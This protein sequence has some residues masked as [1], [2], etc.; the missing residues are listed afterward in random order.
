M[1]I[2]IYIYMHFLHSYDRRLVSGAGL[3][4][5]LAASLSSVPSAVHAR[6]TPVTACDCRR[7]RAR[8]LGSSGFGEPARAARGCLRPHRRL[9]VRTST[10]KPAQLGHRLVALAHEVVALLDH[11]PRVLPVHCPLVSVL[12]IQLRG[13]ALLPPAAGAVG[14]RSG[15]SVHNFFL[16]IGFAF[17]SKFR[18]ASASRPWRSYRKSE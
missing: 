11:L 3:T 9:S 6:S 16:N 4:E 15:S 14:G 10:L 12:R 13:V 2:Y 1:Y 8:P 18:T 7:L 5:C 17:S